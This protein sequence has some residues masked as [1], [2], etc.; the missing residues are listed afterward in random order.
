MLEETRLRD[1]MGRDVIDNDG[2]SIGNLETFFADR[3]TGRPEWLGVFTGT[4]RQRHYLVPVEGADV[5][6]NAIRVPW[7]KDQVKSAPD[8][9]DPETS[10]SEELEREAYSHYGLTPAGVTQR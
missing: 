2:K 6:G 9:S 1:L 10:I 4:F 8:Y 7:T 3:N 5:D